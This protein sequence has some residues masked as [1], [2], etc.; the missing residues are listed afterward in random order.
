MTGVDP[1]SFPFDQYQR[2]RLVQELIVRWLEDRPE[3]SPARILDVGGFA[4][5]VSGDPYLPLA[6]FLPDEEVWAYDLQE[7][8][9]PRYVQID[10]D[11]GAFP[12]E[13]FDVVVA[14][15]VLE[16]VSPD[17]RPL[18]VDKILDTATH[19]AI[20][21]G[22][23][24]D[25]LTSRCESLANLLHRK[26]VGEDDPWLAEHQVNGLPSAERLASIL[27]RRS[28]DFQMIDSGYVHRWLMMMVARIYLKTLPDFEHLLAE[29]NR[30]YNRFFYE[31]DLR[32]PGYRRAFVAATDDTGCSM[33]EKAREI[34]QGAREETDDERTGY[35]ALHLM[36][37]S[38]LLAGQPPD[39][40]LVDGSWDNS[41]LKGPIWGH[42][43][44]EFEVV[45]PL[46]RLCRID[47]FLATYRRRISGPIVIAV[48]SVDDT[49]EVMRQVQLPGPSIQDN[50]WHTI[51]FPDLRDSAGRHYRIE[52]SG[53]DLTK[54]APVALYADDA[55][56]PAHRLY[57]RTSTGAAPTALEDALERERTI[58]REL[59]RER[60][61]RQELEQQVAR[62][63]GR[64]EALAESLEAMERRVSDAAREAEQLRQKIATLTGQLRS[65]AAERDDL[66]AQLEERSRRLG[67]LESR[68]E[69]T[70]RAREHDHSERRRMLLELV[71]AAS[72]DD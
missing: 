68:L 7:W 37:T 2:Y 24:D 12:E 10:P 35:E 56:K 41:T 4:R 61:D 42:H 9:H 71:A 19:A 55:G 72:L 6:V 32:R 25:D 50:H 15:D 57:C 52:V 43:T 11:P 46:D 31:A 51:R 39:E 70:Q 22:P 29:V 13:R 17:A 21:I 58:R 53:Q 40:Q 34:V 1:L 28:L 45:C 23:L 59:E 5:S 60:H 69:E 64:R 14:C 20:I 38:L 26:L 54:K 62:H 67:Q 49:G 33:L 16:H 63:E 65:A 3:G 18:L 8:D 27:R 36:A 30:L 44:V 47:L 48:K 66:L